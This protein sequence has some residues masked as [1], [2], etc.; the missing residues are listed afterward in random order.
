MPALAPTDQPRRRRRALLGALLCLPLVSGCAEVFRLPPPPPEVATALP[1]LG[2]PNARFWPDGPPDALMREAV[3]GARRAAEAAPGAALPPA[4]F[5]A[6]SGGGDNGAFG[7]GLLIGWTAAGTRPSFQVVTGISAGALIAPFAFLGPDYDDALRDLFT[8]VRPADLLRFNSR[9]VAVLFGEAL[10]DTTP[11]YRLIQRHADE[12]MLAAIAREYGRGRLL[13]IGT[14]NLDLQRPVVWN[15]GAIAE[16]GHPRALELFRSILLA[17][18]SIPGAFPP[19]LV[20]VEHAG[21]A[22]QE[23]H[24][25]GGAA[26]QVFLNP[27]QLDLRAVAAGASGLRQRTV[28]V[29]RNGRIDVEGASV[30]RGLFSIASRS[31][32]TLLHFSGVNDISR[33]YLTA[34]R[35]GLDFRLAFIGSE[36]QAPRR[37]PFDP[38][39][40]QA[41]F[42][43]GYAKGLR[44]DG[45][46][47]TLPSVGTVAAQAPSASAA[48]ASMPAAR[49]LAAPARR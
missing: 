27:P 15:I 36:F 3:L 25:D 17:S 33:I 42:D 26:V 40:M 29:V 49:A 18:A 34:Q 21:R 10:A 8:A 38:A 44:G 22:Y 32:T 4:N 1:V 31:I 39:Y 9:V 7:A 14:T 28:H 46:T 41:L 48:A 19:V 6:L 16:S 12:R 2:L 43:Y 24:V 37:E 45:W 23:M 30:T 47:T 20:D 35:D 11:L 5:L 13:M